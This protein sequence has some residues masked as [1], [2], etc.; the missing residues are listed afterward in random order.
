VSETIRVISIIGRFLEHDRVFFFE[1]GGEPKL[2]M[3]S[4]DWRPRNLDRRVEAMVP[5]EDFKTATY[6]R[7]LLD[8]YLSDNR[9]AW[10]LQSAGD[11]IQRQPKPEEPECSTHQMLMQLAQQ[12]SPQ[13]SL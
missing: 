1:H 3:G 13:L 12:R 4:A 5:I 11:Y 9:Q 8:L 10:E 6:L 2:F 7:G